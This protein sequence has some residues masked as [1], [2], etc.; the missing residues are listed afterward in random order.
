MSKTPIIFWLRRDLRLT[1]H[2]GLHEAASSGRAVI[3]VYIRDALVDE[4][5]AAP[6]FRLEK[7]LEAFSALL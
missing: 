3:P 6:K 7:G 5:G 4:L 1:D 2:P